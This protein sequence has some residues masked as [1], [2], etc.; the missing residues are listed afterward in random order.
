MTS[1]LKLRVKIQQ[2]QELLTVVVE[3]LV[4]THFQSL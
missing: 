4:S 3:E 2:K 1:H